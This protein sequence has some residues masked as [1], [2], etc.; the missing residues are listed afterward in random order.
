VNSVNSASRPRKAK[1]AKVNAASADTPTVA[2][3][4]AIAMNVLE[5]IICQNALEPRMSV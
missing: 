2:T 4:V 5:P 1:R 3:A